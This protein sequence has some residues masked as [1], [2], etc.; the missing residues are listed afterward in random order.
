VIAYATWQAWGVAGAP[1]PTRYD[2]DEGVYAETAAAWMRGS[3]PYA[4]IFLSQP[5]ALVATLRA[6]YRVGGPTLLT[7]RA[8][9]IAESVIWLLAL[10]SI[11]AAIGRPRAG[12]FAVCAAAGNAAFALASHTVQPD[13]PSEA[14]G[15]AAV[16]IAVLG[17]RRG[18]LP[19]VA[20]G[21][22][23]GLALLTKLTAVVAATPLL[24]IAVAA[25]LLARDRITPRRT[26]L[27]ALAIGAAAAVAAFLPVIWTPAS[28]SQ[29][30]GY[31]LVAARAAGAAP[32]ANVATEVAF[33]AHAWP[34]SAAAALWMLVGVR[35]VRGPD[36]VGPPVPEW[37][38][39]AL[40][41]WLASAFAVLTALTPLWGHH[42]ILLVSPL[43]LLAGLGVDAALERTRIVP[44]VTLA[45]AAL[46]VAAYLASV[47]TVSGSSPA[48]RAA[49]DAVTRTVPPDADVVTD[50][51]MVPFLAR[52]RVPAAL[53]DTSIVRIESGG[54]TARTL[55]DAMARPN[56]RAVVLWRG[57]F[58]D[59]LPE[60]VGRAA[61]M[62]P[63][64][65][66]RDDG[67]VV[68]VRRDST[69]RHG[70]APGVRHAA[71]VAAAF[72]SRR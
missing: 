16:A 33:L 7:A 21:A 23:W 26:P 18:A 65:V 61:A 11:P 22:A 51:P 35:P 70:P 31:H 46:A 20:A 72:P 32:A 12:L 60:V 44:A 34:L 62:F 14:L 64:V 43:A 9:V 56:V 69:R 24:V 10:L 15:A 53:I 38:A 50:D 45:F 28:A 67:R 55:D 13:G 1:Y 68:R 52:R 40:L 57:T 4:E 54:L 48:L 66:A 49:S 3:R 30:F 27:G 58:R 63:V 5:P 42:L 39:P 41:V 6:A 29:V 8:A 37:L 2:Y 36:R 71:V 17:V 19:W 25:R 59:M 47:A